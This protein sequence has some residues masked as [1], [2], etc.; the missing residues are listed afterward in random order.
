MTSDRARKL[1]DRIME[2]ESG[3]PMRHVDDPP[4]PCPVW[5]VL[6]EA[7]DDLARWIVDDGKIVR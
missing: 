5:L 7:F 2:I 1:H 3:Q 4:T 6:D